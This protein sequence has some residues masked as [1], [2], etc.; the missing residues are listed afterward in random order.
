MTPLTAAAWTGQTDV[1][2]ALLQHGADPNAADANGQRPLLLAVRA[3]HAP[4]VRLLLDKGVPGW[5]QDD[6]WS[7]LTLASFLGDEPIASLLLQHDANVDASD[8]KGM[9]ALMYAASMGHVSIVTALLDKG[10]RID[11]RDA[12]GHTALMF[13]ANNG[14]AAAAAALTS[15]G[16]DAGA[17]NRN[18]RDAASYAAVNGH[19]DVANLIEHSSKPPVAAT[20]GTR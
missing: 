5:L 4:V 6:K 19:T 11:A 20:A 3:R 18:G 9:T 8:D 7:A 2:A 12:G 17:R 1:V 16:A 10:A 13:A 15:A 14:E